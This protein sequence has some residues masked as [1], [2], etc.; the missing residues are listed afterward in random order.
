[1]LVPKKKFKTELKKIKNFLEGEN[2]ENDI[3]KR[4]SPRPS[5]SIKQAKRVSKKGG[6]QVLIRVE[7]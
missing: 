3:Q 4:M 7:A 6:E 1:L 5:Q 2:Q